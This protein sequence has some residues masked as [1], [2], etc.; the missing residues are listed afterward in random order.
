MNHLCAGVLMLTI[1]SK[2]DGQNFAA[3]L[4][5][6]MITPGYFIVRRDPMLQSIHFTSAFSSASPRLSQVENV[7]SPILNGD[8]LN[9]RALECHEFDDSAVE[10][11][12]IELRRGAAFHVS[13]SEPFIGNDECALEL[14][15]V[16]RVDRSMPVA[17]ASL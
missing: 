6:F 15:E 13:T 14:A 9:L 17:D 1:I 11:W 10:C 7:R 5:P 12:G 4:R 8:V 16:F 2:R 3:R